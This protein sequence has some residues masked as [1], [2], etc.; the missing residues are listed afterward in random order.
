MPHPS[1]NIKGLGFSYPGRTIFSNLAMSLEP[2]NIYGLLGLNGAGKSTLL[3]LM[4]GLLLPNSGSIDSLGFEPGE[5]D[6]GYL[7][8][9]FVLPEELH[10]PRVKVSQYLKSL[11]RFYPK[12]SQS[13]FDRC[14]QAFELPADAVLTELSHGQKKK[15]YLSF[16]LACKSSILI[17]DEPTNGLD[18]P[19]K[20]LFRR[21]V[22]EHATE[23]RVFII[24]THQLKDVEALID[25][26]LILHNGRILL[27]AGITELSTILHMELE[28][29]QPMEAEDLLYTEAVVGGHWAVRKGGDEHGRLD[30]EVLF[31]AVIAQPESFQSLFQRSEEGAA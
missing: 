19:S 25:P 22:A 17:M 23:D 14:M 1:I 5:R 20:G 13:Q 15:F 8:D 31:N 24:S 10:L 16:G 27:K 29:A 21:L 28:S 26:L 2:G 3:H 12:F 18:V 4:S 30:M 11:A 9:I 6:P 7:Q